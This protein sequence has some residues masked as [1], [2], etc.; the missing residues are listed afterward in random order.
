M[1]T[2]NNLN[3]NCIGFLLPKHILTHEEMQGVISELSL[4]EQIR[5]CAAYHEYIPLD[6]DYS[7][8]E[9]LEFVISAFPRQNIS[10]K[11]DMLI[12]LRQPDPSRADREENLP[13]NKN[14]LIHRLLENYPEQMEDPISAWREM[15]KTICAENDEFVGIMLLEAV[16]GGGETR[17][18]YSIRELREVKEECDLFLVSMMDKLSKVFALAWKM[19][20]SGYMPDHIAKQRRTEATKKEIKHIMSRVPMSEGERICD[21][22]HEF[23]PLDKEYTLAE[24][25]KYVLATLPNSRHESAKDVARF[26]LDPRLEY[27][28]R[29]PHHEYN[30]NLVAHRFAKE[31]PER[32]KKLADEMRKTSHSFLNENDEWML[33]FLL[34]VV[35]H[36]VGLRFDV[37]SQIDGTTKEKDADLLALVEEFVEFGSDLN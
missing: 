13:Y 37:L 11:H 32:A 9:K 3:R 27:Y 36:L 21:I 28:M 4:Q 14:V 1:S 7:L 8:P 30:K 31:Y 22:F 6:R 26:L 16:F 20:K 34:D 2:Q 10:F 35:D 17:A 12:S 19:K 18:L 24:K 33:I 5:A 15:E 25:M 29:Q 23:I